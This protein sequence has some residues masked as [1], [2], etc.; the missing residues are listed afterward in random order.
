MAHLPLAISLATF[1][2]VFPA[3]AVQEGTC[4]VCLPPCED[5][6]CYKRRFEKQKALTA[7]ANNKC[8]VPPVL[9]DGGGDDLQAKYDALKADYDDV[10]AA[11][12]VCR[13][14]TTTTTMTTISNEDD[15]SVAGVDQC[16]KD[17][18]NCASCC[19]ACTITTDIDNSASSET[20]VCYE[21]TNYLDYGTKFLGSDGNDCVSFVANF[22]QYVYVRNQC[23]EGAWRKCSPRRGEE[24]D[25]RGGLR[26]CGR[27]SDLISP[28][29]S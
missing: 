26:A 3:I 29:A 9:G 21:S 8:G 10:V 7:E 22:V 12:A 24:V 1:F 5:R 28:P 11:L 15:G 14:T 4:E 16:F 18:G 17:G 25:T 13:A 27:D 6:A 20:C 2:F 23:L 19:G